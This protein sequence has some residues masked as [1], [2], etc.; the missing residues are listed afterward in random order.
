MIEYRPVRQALFQAG[1]SGRIDGGEARIRANA[2]KAGE[3]GPPPQANDPDH[4]DTVADWA[5]FESPG[6]W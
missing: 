4:Y 3:R 2:A 5:K 6:E 1:R